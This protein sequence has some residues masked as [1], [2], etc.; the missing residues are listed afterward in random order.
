MYARWFLALAAVALAGCG[1]EGT[2]AEALE[3]TLT[4][5]PEVAGLPVS[6]ATMYHSLGLSEASA[7]LA[8]ARLF[9]SDI[10]LRDAGGNWIDLELVASP[11]QTDRV[12]LIDFEDGT[13]AC[14]DSGTDETNTTIVGLVPVGAYDAVRFRLGVPFELNHLDNAAAPAPF[15]T[16][17]MFWSWR[18]G[19]KFI[20]VD[21]MV[22]DG[23]TSRWNVHVGST[24]CASAAATQAPSEPCANPNVAEVELSGFE[25]HRSVVRVDLAQLVAGVDLHANVDGSPPG[26]MSGPDEGGDCAPVFAS[27]GLEGA[28]DDACAGQT[29][30]S[31]A[32]L[33]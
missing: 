3:V 18:G 8:D 22:A 29:L 17:G 1:E 26:C 24:G 23:S 20:R 10:R 32:P 27:L 9:L 16:P 19:Y 21:W 4:F 12:A 13:G 30:F 15:N 25:L 5:A 6:C 28:C 33:E 11:W 14:R 7:E 31:L 2:P